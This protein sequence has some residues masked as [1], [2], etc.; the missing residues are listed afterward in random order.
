MRP[1]AY[2]PDIY[3][4]EDI[5]GVGIMIAEMMMLDD[6]NCV[7]AGQVTI[8]DV[9]DLSMGHIA[10]ATTTILRKIG[11]IALDASP[12][13]T[14][15]VHL[16][17]LPTAFS[18]IFGFA[19]NFFA[20]AKLNFFVHD[21]MESLYEHIPRYCLPTEYGG[22]AGSLATLNDQLDIKLQSYSDYFKRTEAYGVQES[23]RPGK[24][25]NAEQLFGTD[26]TFRALSID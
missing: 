15:T 10:Q 6:D 25:K 2:D 17:N 3:S 24:P 23:K 1:T 4:M 5:F 26:G 20:E 9:K 12:C 21:S 8:C 14:H 11:S 22:E 19:K 7:V 18:Y 16:I 13:R